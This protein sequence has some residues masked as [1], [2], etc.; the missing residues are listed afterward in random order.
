MSDEHIYIKGLAIG[1]YRSFADYQEIVGLEKVNIFIG[2]NNSGK[3]SLLR[4]IQLGLA[5][6]L[7]GVVPSFDSLDAS[8]FTNQKMIIWGFK[9]NYRMIPNVAYDD[10]NTGEFI[11]VLRDSDSL[12]V[13]QT[14][15]INNPKRTDFVPDKWPHQAKKVWERSQ[16][17]TVNNSLFCSIS[18]TKR[19]ITLT[20]GKKIKVD[21]PQIYYISSMR[22]MEEGDFS[23]FELDG[24][25]LESILEEWQVTQAAKILK[26][27]NLL[28]KITGERAV[29]LIIKTDT[30]GHKE[31]RMTSETNKASRTLSHLGIGVQQTIMLATMC[32]KYERAIICLEEPELHMHPAMQRYFIDFLLETDNQY[33]LTTHSAQ[34]IDTSIRNPK[35]RDDISVFNLQQDYSGRTTVTPIDAARKQD[36]FV[37][38][39]GIGYKASDLLQSN[40]VLWVEGPS[41]KDYINLWLRKWVE[42]YNSRNEDPLPLL[43]E[44]NHYS[45]VFYGGGSITH[46][47]S[48]DSDDDYEFNVLEKLLPLNRNTFVLADSDQ[49]SGDWDLR[50]GKLRAK[51]ELFGGGEPKPGWIR[52]GWITDGREIENYIP[53]DQWQ[54]LVR[55]TLPRT[56]TLTFDDIDNIEF[57][58]YFSLVHKENGKS[59]FLNDEKTKIASVYASLFDSKNDGDK[60]IFY[61]DLSTEKRTIAESEDVNWS[62][63]IDFSCLQLGKRVAE[64]YCRICRANHLESAQEFCDKFEAAQQAVQA[65][66]LI[67]V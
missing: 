2:K 63:E 50:K 4:L 52:F 41:D 61:P 46:L 1:G 11:R 26:V 10:P 3:T 24:K 49:G 53:Y 34:I 30:E 56:K 60:L 57:A 64:L 13:F 51:M 7:A 17:T 39:S 31:L 32:L 48:E 42:Y 27:C 15:L 58:D 43:E 67:G 21:Y 35:W 20:D 36:L 8:V 38:L 14:Q 66:G 6:W 16:M 12:L 62:P 40:S 29:K 47:K 45:I 55:I 65:D 37:A 59:G 23:E 22:H 18:T 9:P 19:E 5:K 44:G 54:K 25:G 28:G 33:F